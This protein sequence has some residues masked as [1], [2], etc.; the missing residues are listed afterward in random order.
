MHGDQDTTVHCT[1]HNLLTPYIKG[2]NIHEENIHEENSLNLHRM[3][4]N[5]SII[6]KTDRIFQ[7]KKRFLLMRFS[8]HHKKQEFTQ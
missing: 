1:T 7:F 2:K 6:T 3:H 4:K 5:S 8:T